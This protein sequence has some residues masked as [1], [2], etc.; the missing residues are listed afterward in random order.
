[1]T[2]VTF[3][4]RHAIRCHGLNDNFIYILC[5]IFFGAG[6]VHGNLV[7]LDENGQV[8]KRFTNWLSSGIPFGSTEFILT[9]SSSDLML[10]AMV[11]SNPNEVV[12]GSEV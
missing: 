4:E 10:L 7:C 9:V 1:M 12:A 3:K 8:S 11:P 2:L 6:G 5:A